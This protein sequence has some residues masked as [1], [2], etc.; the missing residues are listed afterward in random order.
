MADHVE[1][2]VRGGGAAREFDQAGWGGGG[3]GGGRGGISRMLET[4]RVGIHI[5]TFSSSAPGACGL[6][7]PE[8]GRPREMK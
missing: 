5:M 2:L 6:H 8:K 7:R 1:L 3:G 4:G